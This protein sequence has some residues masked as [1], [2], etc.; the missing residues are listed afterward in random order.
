VGA[1]MHGRIAIATSNVLRSAMCVRHCKCTS[2]RR[3]RSCD[4]VVALWG[5]LQQGCTA[6]SAVTQAARLH[7]QQTTG[8]LQREPCVTHFLGMQQGGWRRM[9]QT[10]CE[11]RVYTLCF[12]S[13]AAELRQVG[14]QHRQRRLDAPKCKSNLRHTFHRSSIVN[15]YCSQSNTDKS[16][17]GTAKPASQAAATAAASA[18]LGD[19]AKLNVAGKV[20]RGRQQARH[21]DG[22]IPAQG[23]KPL[24]HLLQCRH[25]AMC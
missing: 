9:T 21:Q 23:R 22:S 15:L 6:S 20:A 4:A 19:D 8:S 2:I 10:T 24:N 14:N 5:T 17:G 1:A 11:K 12:C 18:H 16:T 25:H 7:A 3:L 13:E